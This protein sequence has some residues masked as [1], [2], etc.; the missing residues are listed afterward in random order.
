MTCTVMVI[1]ENVPCYAKTKDSI[2]SVVGSLSK[3]VFYFKM[4]MFPKKAF[5]DMF[6]HVGQMKVMWHTSLSAV[7]SHSVFDI[8]PL[9][10]VKK[11]QLNIRCAWLA[12]Q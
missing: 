3:Y 5:S 2:T 11:S 7:V 10:C 8:I 4:T 12:C 9:S 1:P 6:I